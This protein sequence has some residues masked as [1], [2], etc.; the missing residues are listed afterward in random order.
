MTRF[1]ELNPFVLLSALIIVMSALSYVVPAGKYERVIQPETKRT[2]VV[3]GSFRYTARSPVGLS[4]LFLS[5]P[6]GMVNAAVIIF[7][8]FI[9]AGA[10]RILEDIGTINASIYA[11]VQRVRGR[12][13]LLIPVIMIAFAVMGAVASMANAVIIFIPLGIVIAQSLKF[14]S[15]V[16]LGLVY[17]GCYAG[18]NTSP[19]VP[20]SVGI[21]HQIGQ[22]PIFSG[23]LVR[24]II[25][26]ITVLVT[27][28]Y[29]WRYAAR[30]KKDPSRSLVA[31]L[32]ITHDFDIDL[33]ASR[34]MG[35]RDWWVL[36]VVGLTM[37][38]LVFGAVEYQWDLL[39]ISALFVAMAVVTGLVGGLGPNK[40]ANSFVKGMAGITSG[41]VITGFAYAIQYVLQKG[42]IMDTI[43]HFLSG[44]LSGLPATVAALGMYVANCFI[45]LLITS[46]SG[47]AAAVMP[48]M[49]PIGD[50]V[51]LTRQVTTQAF[52]FA[53]GFM[54]GITPTSGVLMACLAI[55]KVPFGRWV[56][57]YLPLLGL[58]TLIAVVT[59]VLGVKFGWGS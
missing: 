5:I 27:I 21:A 59:L 6:K 2:M 9:S 32:N 18:F 51:G 7:G 13:L 30:V 25:C 14:D 15:V 44:F 10:F 45:A 43:I 1:K 11:L 4:D 56:R 28:G 40:L 34:P 49:F 23:A 41:A 53:D 58:W 19:V 54:N 35:K 16:G 31:D 26:L 22:L 37:V 46:G 39:E 48:I 38:S 57:F 33:K 17:L 20:T 29:V 55:A 24:T 8:I 47:Q 42:M 50:L 12:E 52:L 3:P 36:G